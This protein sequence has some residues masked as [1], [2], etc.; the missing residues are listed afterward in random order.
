MS[1]DFNKIRLDMFRNLNKCLNDLN[2]MEQTRKQFTDEKMNKMATDEIDDSGS[3]D[4]LKAQ[5]DDVPFVQA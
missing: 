1:H 5:I 4:H 2:S 3:L